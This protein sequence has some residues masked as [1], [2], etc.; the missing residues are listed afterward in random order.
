MIGRI[1]RSLCCLGGAFRQW[2]TLS[3]QLPALNSEKTISGC[4]IARKAAEAGWI[5]FCSASR[6]SS[7]SF[8]R[9]FVRS[10]SGVDQTC[11]Q[12]RLS[13]TQSSQLLAQFWRV[14]SCAQCA[15]ISQVGR[16]VSKG[17]VH[18]WPW[19]PP[20]IL[21]IF[22]RGHMDSRSVCKSGHCFF[23]WF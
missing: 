11:D 9:R 12:L 20:S 23:L 22:S 16:R 10:R 5:G 18:F 8:V 19:Q 13:W 6:R 17:R 7:L 15:L 3:I 4:T 21:F 1:S 14:F 2:K